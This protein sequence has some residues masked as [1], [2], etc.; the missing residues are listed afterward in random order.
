MI[1]C[2]NSVG[3]LYTFG[4]CTPTSAATLHFVCHVNPMFSSSS[5]SPRSWCPCSLE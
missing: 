1:L 5:W 4:A 3:D 2:C